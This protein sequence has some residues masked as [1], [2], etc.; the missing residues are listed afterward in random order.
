MAKVL[1]AEYP[2][3]CIGCEMCVFETQHQLK[4]IGLEGALIRIFRN[5]KKDRN[6][7][8]VDIDP[9]INTTATEKIK[10]SCPQGVFVIED[11]S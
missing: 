4:K 1:K 2:D 7:F 8:S 5:R 3:R 9:R 11:E 10:D 6:I